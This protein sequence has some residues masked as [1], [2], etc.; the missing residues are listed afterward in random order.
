MKTTR[1]THDRTPRQDQT[2]I[3]FLKR[4]PQN[5]GMHSA[6]TLDASSLII[7]ADRVCRQ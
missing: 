1:N 6:K 3:W 7:P 2:K 4:I 5:E